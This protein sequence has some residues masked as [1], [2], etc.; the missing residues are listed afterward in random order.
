MAGSLILNQ[1]FEESV[2][3]LVGDQEFER[4]RNTQ[5]YSYAIGTFD[6]EVKTSFRG[7]SKEE[8]FVNFP[9]ASLKDDPEGQLQAN[10]WRMTGYV[11]LF[12]NSLLTNKGICLCKSRDDVKVIFDPVI[13]E[14][15][16][17]VDGQVKSVKAKRK[18]KD[19]TV[20]RAFCQPRE[21]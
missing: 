13:A 9:M 18:N 21:T 8:Y 19:V 1:R 3:N 20:S 11:L 5:G 14:V 4:L 7:H 6:R 12:L 2:K 17:F 16:R 15:L 10:C